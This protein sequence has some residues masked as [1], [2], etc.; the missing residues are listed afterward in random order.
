[1]I[2]CISP[3]FRI[4]LSCKEKGENSIVIYTIPIVLYG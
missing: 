3:V 4:L 2:L 1:M